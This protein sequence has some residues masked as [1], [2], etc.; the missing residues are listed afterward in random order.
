MIMQASSLKPFVT[1]CVTGSCV[2]GWVPGKQVGGG[3]QH[4]ALALLFCR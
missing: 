3:A 4:S 1:E 2:A